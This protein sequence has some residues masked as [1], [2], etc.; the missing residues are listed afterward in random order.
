MCGG[1]G[2]GTTVLSVDSVWC[3]EAIPYFILDGSD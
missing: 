2:E 1:P 3:E